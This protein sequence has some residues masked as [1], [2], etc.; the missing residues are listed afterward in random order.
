M[1]RFGPEPA[2]PDAAV[3]FLQK[4]RSICVKYKS[5]SVIEMLRHN[6]SIDKIPDEKSRSEQKEA[7]VDWPS[8][9]AAREHLKTLVLGIQAIPESTRGAV[10]EAFDEAATAF[11]VPAGLATMMPT[12][13]QVSAIE[14][15]LR[16]WGVK[17]VFDVA[18]GMGHM[19]SIL[20]ARGFEAIATAPPCTQI[21]PKELADFRRFCGVVVPEVLPRVPIRAYRRADN[22]SMALMLSSVQP[23]CNDESKGGPYTC[24]ERHTARAIDEFHSLGENYLVIMGPAGPH[25]A[26][27]GPSGFIC[28]TCFR[29]LDKYRVVGSCVDSAVQPSRGG[30]SPTTLRTCVWFYEARWPID[31][32]LSTASDVTQPPSHLRA[33]VVKELEIVLLPVLSQVVAD[34]VESGHMEVDGQWTFKETAVRCLLSV[35]ADEYDGTETA[36]A[37]RERVYIYNPHAKHRNAAFFP[38]TQQLLPDFARPTYDDAVMSLVNKQGKNPNGHMGRGPLYATSGNTSKVTLDIQGYAHPSSSVVF[39]TEQ[40]PGNDVL[41][42]FD[43]KEDRVLS[44]THVDRSLW[45]CRVNADALILCRRDGHPSPSPLSGH[46]VQFQRIGVDGKIDV[47]SPASPSDAIYTE[48]TDR[49]AFLSRYRTGMIYAREDSVRVISF[50]DGKYA[51]SER[52]ALPFSISGIRENEL[53]AVLGDFLYILRNVSDSIRDT[54]VDQLTRISL[55]GTLPPP[56]RFAV[57]PAAAAAV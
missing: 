45:L 26:P 55:R 47:L 50:Q 30:A 17:T 19:S 4:L 10:R 8:F 53:V 27:T 22:T 3:E 24:K 56:S 57:A 38:R 31:R 18:A 35:P 9:L 42:A 29:A 13:K 5:H 33:S 14:K 48:E 54:G 12:P 34:F 32:T 16:A 7:R 52:Y 49:I 39:V 36:A 43:T 25:S 41:V 1:K 2:T 51:C 21:T 46:Q 28:S 23:N 37:A 40:H 6:A 20:R 44:R 11:S 15:Q